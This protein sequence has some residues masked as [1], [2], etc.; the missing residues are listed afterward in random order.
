MI[1]RRNYTLEQ[2]VQTEANPDLISEF[3]RSWR[4][5]LSDVL[6]DNFL[7]DIFLRHIGCVEP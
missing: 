1:L 6:E 3:N 2:S 5:A 4:I 7:E